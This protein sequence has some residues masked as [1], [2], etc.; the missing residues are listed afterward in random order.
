MSKTPLKTLTCSSVEMCVNLRAILVNSG[1]QE[2]SSPVSSCNSQSTDITLNAE[3]PHV[4]WQLSFN[5]DST[6]LHFVHLQTD[7]GLINFK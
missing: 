3:T 2:D 7:C 1:R 6:G 5:C 4:T